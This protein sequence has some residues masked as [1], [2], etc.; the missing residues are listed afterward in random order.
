MQERCQFLKCTKTGIFHKFNQNDRGTIATYGGRQAQSARKFRLESPSLCR[1]KMTAQAGIALKS[2]RKCY[3]FRWARTVMCKVATTRCSFAHLFVVKA[4]ASKFA[5]NRSSV[6]FKGFRN[7][8]HRTVGFQRFLQQVLFN[9]VHDFRQ[10]LVF[11][12]NRG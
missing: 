7:F 6:D 5:K 3:P 1:Y 10:R 2:V 4:I 12:C 8:H 11:G 9:A